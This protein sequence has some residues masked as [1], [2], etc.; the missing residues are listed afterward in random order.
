MKRTLLFAEIE[1]S[2]LLRR[3]EE[4]DTALGKKIQT[5][6]LRPDTEPKIKQE[7]AKASK[8]FAGQGGKFP[9][10]WYRCNLRQIAEK[11]NL[12]Q[13]YDFIVFGYNGAVHG[14]PYNMVMGSVIIRRHLIT[15]AWD[16]V[17]RV[18]D[19]NA[20]YHQLDLSKNLQEA[21]ESARGNAVKT[22]M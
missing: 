18:M 12:V 9:N 17:L 16:T 7:F 21:F 10:N 2:K 1:R 20:K 5:S 22:F 15:L 13:E 8:R 3:I 11:L 19:A 6:P 4:S 14:S